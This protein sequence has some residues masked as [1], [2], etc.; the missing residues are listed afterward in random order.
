LGSTISGTEGAGCLRAQAQRADVE[1]ASDHD[2]LD[3]LRDQ[4]EAIALEGAEL[5]VLDHTGRNIDDWA[6]AVL[7]ETS[8]PGSGAST[9]GSRRTTALMPRTALGC[10]SESE[11]ETEA[12]GSRRSPS[13]GRC[14]RRGTTALG[15]PVSLDRLGADYATLLVRAKTAVMLA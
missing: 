3:A 10:S 2:P 9:A 5:A 11:A 8:F 6:D 4:V 13:R 1:A 7:R 15:S 12:L 14:S